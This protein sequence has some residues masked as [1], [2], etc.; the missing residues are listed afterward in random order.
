MIQFVYKE[1]GT[2][3]ELMAIPEGRYAEMFLAQARYYRD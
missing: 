1:L 2:H 3:E